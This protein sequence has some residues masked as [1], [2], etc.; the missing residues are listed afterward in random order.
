MKVPFLVNADE[1]LRSELAAHLRGEGRE[2]LEVDEQRALELCQQRVDA[3]FVWTA[4]E[5]RR[6]AALLR[7]LEGSPNAQVTHIM[8]CAAE[9]AAPAAY[10]EEAAPESEARTLVG[11]TTAMRDL[12][13]TVRRLARRPRTHVLVCGEPGTGKQ[14]LA[15]ALHEQTPETQDFVRVTPEHLTALLQAGL[16]SFTDG[17]TLYAPAIDE[18]AKSDQRRLAGL[19]ADHDVSGAAP[20]RLVI[21]T[22]AST[23]SP[24]RL[25]AQALHPELA[26]RVPVLLDLL[27]LRKRTSDIPLL[28]QHLLASWSKG[29]GLSVPELTP[30][31]LEKLAAHG[32]PGNVRELG[33]VLEQAWLTGRRCLD[34]QDLPNFEPSRGGVDY[35]LPSSGIDF[36]EFERAMLAQAL[37][38]SR[39]NQTQAASLLGLTRDQVRYRMGKFKLRRSNGDTH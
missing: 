39:G 34:V 38:L 5:V 18:I 30:A 13:A 4:R 31:A 7:E 20:V 2:V 21:G 3:V 35:E 6:A 22:R 33:N 14:T 37:A 23:S 25:I 29:S 15:R 1:R 27:P 11:E 28:A 8:V 9:P 26:A 10:A 24:G 32:W 19:L 12:R 17:A 36:F 16:R